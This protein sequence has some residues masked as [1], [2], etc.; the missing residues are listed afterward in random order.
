VVGAGRFAPSPT[1]L[2]HL[3][4]LLAAAAS[5]VDARA[6]GLDWQVRL[7]DLDT[8]R[9]QPGAEDGILTA[10]E[11]HGLCWDGP[12]V[13][14]SQ[15]LDRYH[16]ALSRLAA[17]DR[18][19]YCGCS[20]SL[21]ARQRRYPG[22]C[23]ARRAP[24]DGCAVRVRVDDDPVVFD[25]VFQGPQ[26]SVLTEN[27]GDFVVRRRDG[28]IAYQLATAVDD[29][30]AEIVRVI[31]GRDLL[32]NTPRQIWLMR[33]LELQTPV[34]GHLPLLLNASGQKLSKQTH[35]EPLNLARPADNLRRVLTALGV[36]LP[37]DAVELDCA[38]L[39]AQAVA[40]WPPTRM[41]RHDA[42]MAS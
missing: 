17:D 42:I 25:D 21:L 2:L 3:G 1:G 22:T 7:D 12:V 28:V 40:A 18:L 16:A 6:C 13:R 9:R 26:R 34:Y 30:A 14:Q 27:V 39:L 32:D 10:L 33:C 20:R 35:A 37:A 11:R 8:V 19:F 36:D 38:V 41:P 29:G 15:R 24:T 5:F 23:R 31:R 4:S